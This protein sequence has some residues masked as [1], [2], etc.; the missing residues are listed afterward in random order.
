CQRVAIHVKSGVEQILVDGNPLQILSHDL[1]RRDPLRLERRAHL[2]DAGLDDGEGGTLGVGV[3]GHDSDNDGDEQG[4]P[5]HGW[6]FRS[7]SFA[8]DSRWT[9]SGPSAMRMVRA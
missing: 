9:S 6:Y 7:S 8:I 3:Q 5:P 1:F 2:G 4:D